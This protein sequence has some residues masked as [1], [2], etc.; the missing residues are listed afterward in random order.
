MFTVFIGQIQKIFNNVW[1]T[2]E[3]TQCTGPVLEIFP[4]PKSSLI[5]IFTQAKRVVKCQKL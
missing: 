4:W 1:D 2:V 5:A 3:I